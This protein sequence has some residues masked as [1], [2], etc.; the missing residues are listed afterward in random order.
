[1][2]FSKIA[3]KLVKAEAFYPN[4]QSFYCGTCPH[5]DACRNWH[6]EAARRIV[7]MAA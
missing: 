2:E 4:E 3:E 7:N 5:G 1:V 6:R